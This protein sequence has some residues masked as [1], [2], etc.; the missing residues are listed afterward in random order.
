VGLVGVNGQLEA[1][2]EY[3]DVELTEMVQNWKE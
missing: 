3:E 1:D 2:T